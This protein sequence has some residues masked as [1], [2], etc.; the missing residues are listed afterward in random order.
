MG[1]QFMVAIFEAKAFQK[2]GHVVRSPYF[3]QCIAVNFIRLSAP[4][5]PAATDAPLALP[6]GETPPKG[7]RR[8]NSKPDTVQ[9]ATAYG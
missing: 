1:P 3:I 8:E 7:E 9:R 2:A 4:P 5:T 6:D